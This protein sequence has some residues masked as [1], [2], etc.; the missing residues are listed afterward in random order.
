MPLSVL[1]YFLRT[2]VLDRDRPD[3]DPADK[4]RFSLLAALVP[5]TIG[6]VLPF[7]VENNLPKADA[8]QTGTGGQLGTSIDTGTGAQPGTSTGTGTGAQPGMSPGTGT[9]AQPGTS[10]GTGAIVLADIVGRL[11]DTDLRIEVVEGQLTSINQRL[12]GANARLDEQG[13]QL[14]RIDVV[15]Q[16]IKAQ[17]AASAPKKPVSPGSGS[18]LS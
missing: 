4:A 9:G 16:E 6:L 2:T 7:I 11:N 18:A 8:V 1:N 13:Q 5:G 14:Q 17:L 10:T 3:A 12:D 15:T